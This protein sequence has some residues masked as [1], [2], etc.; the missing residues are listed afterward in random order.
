MKR[1]FEQDGFIVTVQ[2]VPD[3]SPDLSWLEQDYADLPEPEATEYRKHYRKRLVAYNRGEWYMLG[4]V[5]SVA[6][7]VHGDIPRTVGSASLWGIES[8]DEAYIAEV[9]KDL[10]H[11]AIAD[12]DKL[13]EALTHLPVR[14]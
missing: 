2:H 8:D 14:S 13:V 11:E 1:T 4:V 6:I 3:E 12:A 9:E 10:L 5:V 7:K